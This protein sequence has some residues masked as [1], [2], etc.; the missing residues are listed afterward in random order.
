MLLEHVTEIIEHTNTDHLAVALEQFNAQGVVS[1]VSLPFLN[2][3]YDNAPDQLCTK[4]VSAGFKGTLQITKIENDE[5]E[6]EYIVFDSSRF[7]LLTAQKWFK[8]QS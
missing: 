6:R 3:V 2:T 4:L 5:G 1:S 7:S 8:T